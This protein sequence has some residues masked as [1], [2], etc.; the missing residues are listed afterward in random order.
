MKRFLPALLL[1]ATLPAAAEKADVY[2]QTTIKCDECRFDSVTGKANMAGN[3]IITRGT[4]RIEADRGEALR[5][6][7]GYQSAAVQ[8]D[9]GRKVRFR[10]KSDGPGEVW[11]EGEASRVEYDERSGMV[12][13]FDE[14]RVRRVV[15]GTAGDEIQGDAIIYNLRTEMIDIRPLAPGSRGTIILQPKRKPPAAAVATTE[16]P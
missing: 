3:I 12:K 2:R 16:K 4:L 6:P 11:M 10:Q 1:A 8:A 5:S 14:G 13:L 15:D 7:E 9:P